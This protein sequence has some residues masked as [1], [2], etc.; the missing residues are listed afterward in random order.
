M[1]IN[2]N[3]SVRARRLRD[4]ILEAFGPSPYPGDCNISHLEGEE[5]MDVQD[6]FRGKDWKQ[7]VENPLELLA[8]QHECV[9][10]FT[11]E[12]F[13]YFLPLFFLAMIQDKEARQYLFYD[14]VILSFISPADGYWGRFYGTDLN[15][16]GP[17]PKSQKECESFVQSARSEK[18]M[19]LYEKRIRALS[20]QQR[21]AAVHF[22]EFMKEEFPEEEVDDRIVVALKYLREAKEK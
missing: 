7:W 22:L 1:S 3:R 19:R 12:A 15:F 20:S 5:S 4:K 10:F 2:K 8:P 6:H 21:E 14:A 13:R 9:S 11:A 16:F 17:G 18:K